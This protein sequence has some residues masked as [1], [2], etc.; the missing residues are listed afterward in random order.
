SE[1]YE[2]LKALGFAI[3]EGTEGEVFISALPVLIPDAQ[4]GTV[5]E[6]LLANWKQQ[7]GAEGF[8]EA[9]RMARLLSRALSIRPGRVLDTA[10][11]QALI[12]DLFACK[13]P[14]RSPFNKKIHSTLGVDEL[15]K[16]LQ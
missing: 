5:L 1:M 8:S 2:S 7:L 4:V 11:R 3:E 12:N 15:E 6:E 16:K 10:S 14:D 13:D 9:D